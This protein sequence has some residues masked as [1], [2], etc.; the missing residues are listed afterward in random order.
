[1]SELFTVAEVALMFLLFC[2]CAPR[3]VHGNDQRD[4]QAPVLTPNRWGIEFVCE[5]SILLG[6]Y[7]N[8]LYATKRPPEFCV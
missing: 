7:G 3:Y 2:R 5:Y 6:S 8:R 4:R 1:M